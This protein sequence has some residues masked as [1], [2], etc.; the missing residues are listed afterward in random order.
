[1]LYQL[2]YMRC[3]VGNMKL[4]SLISNGISHDFSDDPKKISKVFETE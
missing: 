3:G 1:M 2:S 4:G